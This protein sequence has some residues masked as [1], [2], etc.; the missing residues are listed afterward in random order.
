MSNN[1]ILAIG[2]KCPINSNLAQ[3]APECVN[4]W[5]QNGSAFVGML[6]NDNFKDIF[7]VTTID[8]E[9]IEAQFKDYSKLVQTVAVDSEWKSLDDRHDWFEIFNAGNPELVLLVV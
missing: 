2:H 1:V 4:V 8:K 9:K 3:Y 6:V 7:D 5:H